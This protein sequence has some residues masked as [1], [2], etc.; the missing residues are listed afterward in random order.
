M[1]ELEDLYKTV[2][3]H[4]TEFGNSKL[5]KNNSIK[6]MRPKCFYM[7]VATYGK[8]ACSDLRFAQNYNKQHS[9]T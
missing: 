4:I 7:I 8:G 5:A 2:S 3:T 6:K 1:L 9:R